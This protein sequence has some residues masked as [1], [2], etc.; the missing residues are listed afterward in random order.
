MPMLLVPDIVHLADVVRRQTGSRVRDLRVE[1]RPGRVVLLGRAASYYAKQ[2]AQH[3]LQDALPADQE[4]E[5]SI[6]VDSRPAELTPASPIFQHP[7]HSETDQL[8]GGIQ[9]QLVAD[10][11]PVR[12]HSLGA[13]KQPRGNFLSRLAPTD[14]PQHLQLTVG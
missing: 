5:N 7:L 9:T 6:I 13:K 14:R 8:L 12:R 10:A 2:L 4:L 11:V 1:L 3:G